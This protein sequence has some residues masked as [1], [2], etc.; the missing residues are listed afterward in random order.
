MLLRTFCT[1]PSDQWLKPVGLFLWK[2]SPD[3]LPQLWGILKGD[4]RFVG[5]QPAL[6]NQDDP[7]ALRAAAGAHFLVPGLTDWAQVNGRGELPSAQTVTLDA[8]Y[9]QQQS[10]WFDLRF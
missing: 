1:S 2:S 6:S 4:M 9:V 10:G 8:Q 3:E 5:P 7:I